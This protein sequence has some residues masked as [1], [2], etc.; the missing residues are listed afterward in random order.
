MKRVLLLL[1]MDVR[2]Y[3]SAAITTTII[4]PRSPAGERERLN[5]GR[6]GTGQDYPGMAPTPLQPHAG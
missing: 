5:R 2:D 3:T 6:D 4:R 1:Q